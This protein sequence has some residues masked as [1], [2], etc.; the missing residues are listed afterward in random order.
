[1]FP[2]PDDI[3]RLLR[4]IFGSDHNSDPA[5]LVWVVREERLCSEFK[6]RYGLVLDSLAQHSLAAI[7]RSGRKR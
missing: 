3:N 4:N 2:H 7:V 1:M 5:Y 6:D